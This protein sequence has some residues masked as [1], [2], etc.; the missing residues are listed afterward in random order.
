MLKAHHIDT[1]LG[2]YDGEECVAHIVIETYP[3]L[4]KKIDIYTPTADKNG[5]SDFFRTDSADSIKEALD[6]IESVYLEEHIELKGNRSET[7][8]ELSYHGETIGYVTENQPINSFTATSSEK[9]QIGA[10][11]TYKS[12]IA[13]LVRNYLDQKKG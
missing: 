7:I 11:K 3:H 13:A 1:R 5:R 2:V 9:F 4:C 6:K 10:Y 12:A 8:Y